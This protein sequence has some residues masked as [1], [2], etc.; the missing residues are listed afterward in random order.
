MEALENKPQK[1]ESKA[2]LNHRFPLLWRFLPKVKT[3]FCFF[4][5]SMFFSPPLLSS[6]SS[7]P[8]HEN[9]RKDPVKTNTELLSKVFSSE[10]AAVRILLIFFSYAR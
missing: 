9:L 3:N 10:G 1:Y 6:L 4:F 7:F 2:I 8:V 5:S